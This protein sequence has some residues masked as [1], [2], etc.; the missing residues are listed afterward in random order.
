[1]TASHERTSVVYIN[2]ITV[3]VPG[4][5]SVNSCA[6]DRWQQ[7]RP[8]V[9]FYSWCVLRRSEKLNHESAVHATPS[10]LYLFMYLYSKSDSGVFVSVHHYDIKH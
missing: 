9:L 2:I 8:E 6:D 7:Y 4:L 5:R 10:I 1:M 3:V